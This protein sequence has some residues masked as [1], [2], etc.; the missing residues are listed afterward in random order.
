MKKPFPPWQELRPVYLNQLATERVVLSL[1][2]SLG[3]EVPEGFVDEQLGAI[4]ENLGE[5]TTFEESLSEAGL[6]SEDL[7]RTLIAEAELSRQTVAAL[8]E[9]LSVP[10]YLV[11][12]QLRE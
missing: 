2:R 6:A 10:D 12:T 8:R 3:A 9:N 4:R 7:L 5:E 1:G 11:E